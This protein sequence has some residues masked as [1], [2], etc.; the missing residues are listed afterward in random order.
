M[1][2]FKHSLFEDIIAMLVGCLMASLG[3]FFLKTTAMVSG[4]VTGTALLVSQFSNL[5]FGQLL[6]LFNLPFLAFAARQRGWIFTLRSIFCSVLVAVF[7]DNMHHVLENYK[8]A[9]IYAAIMGGFLIGMG[10]LI[11]IRHQASL[12]GFTILALYLQERFNWSTGYLQL[13]FDSSI[14][15]VS[16]FLVPTETI[17][18]SVLAAACL[19]LIIILNHKNGRYRVLA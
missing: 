14:I 18:L 9:P 13:V 19:N 6:L 17:A 8:L 1:D 2:R 12:G 3:I 11:M 10:L 4:G 15:I 7:T 5:S 16:F